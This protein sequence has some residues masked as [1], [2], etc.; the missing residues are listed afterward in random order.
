MFFSI[1]FCTAEVYFANW[2]VSSFQWRIAEGLM[3]GFGESFVPNL[4]VF[5]LNVHFFDTLL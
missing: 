2:R 3:A 4:V 1:G 5:F